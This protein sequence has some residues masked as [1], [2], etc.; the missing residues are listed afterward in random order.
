MAP[1]PA[2]RRPVL[3]RRR[4]STRRKRSWQRPRR[5]QP[6]C[7]TRSPAHGR[8]WQVSPHAWPSSRHGGKAEA[9]SRLSASS[10]TS[11]PPMTP[12]RAV[13][14]STSSLH[15]SKHRP[16]PIRSW[17]AWQPRLPPRS[18]PPIFPQSYHSLSEEEERTLRRRLLLVR[19]SAWA[20][21]QRGG[22]R[23][24]RAPMARVRR[25]ELPEKAREL[26]SM[27]RSSLKGRLVRR[28]TARTLQSSSA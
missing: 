2:R 16:P 1:L 17:I 4:P 8:Q 22:L 13:P 27:M 23:K 6:G 21:W 18:W 19:R 9:L 11:S 24:F 20:R 28:R 12:P 14:R 10:S 15:R 3:A 7:A 25:S 5:R 26:L